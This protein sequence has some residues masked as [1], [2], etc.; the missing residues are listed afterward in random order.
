M[1]TAAVQLVADAPASPETFTL[2]GRTYR[3]ATASMT[4]AQQVFVIGRLKRAGIATAG[5][6]DIGDNAAAARLALQFENAI[7]AAFESGEMYEIL[8]GLLLEPGATWSR[9]RALETAALIQTVTDP[10]ESAAIFD[11]A[12]DIVIDFFR[13]AASWNP[14][15]PTSTLPTLDSDLARGAS[16]PSSNT[17]SDGKSPTSSAS[18][19]TPS[20]TTAP[21][22]ASSASSPHGT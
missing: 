21:T 11:Y 2:N 19:A 20:T 17:V 6:V 7:W 1:S 3:R 22:T 10:D 4:V 16:D 9:Q 5:R 14:T 13:L 12:A 15:S 8:G 18:A